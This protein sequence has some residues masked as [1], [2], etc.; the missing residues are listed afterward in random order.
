MSFRTEE[1]KEGLTDL[2]GGLDAHGDS[3]REFG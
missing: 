2:G 3:I 1:V